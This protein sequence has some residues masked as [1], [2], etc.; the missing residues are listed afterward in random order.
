MRYVD[1]IKVENKKCILFKENRKFIATPAMRAYGILRRSGKR[2]KMHPRERCVLHASLLAV[3]IVE[4][5][6][7]S[8]T[9]HIHA[10]SYLNDDFVYA[11]AYY[12]ESCHYITEKNT[13]KMIIG[14]QAVTVFSSFRRMRGARNS[15]TTFSRPN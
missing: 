14:R 7:D 15:L 9:A 1:E 6:G 4:K 2:D 5:F 3:S 10:C 12:F 13:S 8:N 11:H